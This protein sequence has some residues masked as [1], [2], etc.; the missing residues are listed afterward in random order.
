MRSRVSTALRLSTAVLILAG[1]LA[2]ATV[3]AYGP[4]ILAIPAAILPLAPLGEACDR[5]FSAYRVITRAAAIIY[6][7][8]IPLTVLILGLMNAVIALIVFIQIYTLLKVKEERNYH[9]LFLMSFFLL[10]AACVQQPDAEIALVMLLFLVSA[11]WAF[12]TLRLHVESARNTRRA[13]P[14]IVPLRGS[15]VRAPDETNDLFDWGLAFCITLVSLSGALLT[16]GTF[17]LTPR[18]EAGFL[19]RSEGYTQ[20]TGLSRDISLTGAAYLR[21]DRS[22]VMRIEFPEEPGGRFTGPMYW[23]STSLASYNASTWSHAGL[24]ESYD[25]HTRYLTEGQLGSEAS[26]RPRNRDQ[27]AVHQVIYMDEV[28]EEGVPCLDLVQKVQVTGKPGKGRLAWARGND[29]TIVLLQQEVRHLSYEVWSEMGITNPDVLR[30]DPADYLNYMQP[31]DF[32]L[33]THHDLRPETRALAERIT[34]GHDT[35]YDKAAAIAQWLS[36]PD[37]EYTL[38]LPPMPEQGAI[39][40]FLLRVRRGHCQFFAGGMALMLRSLGIP[41]RVVSGYRGGEWNPA[42]RSYTVRASMAH[43]W[44]EVLFPSYGW[45]VFDPAPRGD[46]SP[47]SGWA[48]LL[49]AVSRNLLKAKMLWYQEVVAYDRAQQFQRLRNLSLGLFR[50]RP[51][52]KL[53]AASAAKASTIE[54]VGRWVLIAFAASLVVFLVLLRRIKIPQRLVLTEDQARAVRLYRRLCR[55]LARYGINTANRPA[56]EID[57]AVSFSNRFDASTV[58]SLITVY[59][60]VRFGRRTLPKTV[61]RE[62]QKQIRGLRTRP[63]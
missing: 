39:D 58:H 32:S 33:L 29:F 45:V 42:D 25:P 61:F 18:I 54:R 7:C 22:A 60:K 14:D 49:G 57:E 36:G 52:D 4:M 56:E 63:T 51:Q 12:L 23:R 9:H 24:T 1:Y 16:A 20:R 28:P 59:N 17:L 10:L 3:H 11:V 53:E 30:R 43:V 40:A 5:R 6:G 31:R 55:Q 21:E 41:A 50:E 34:A 2:L 8:F 46:D 19:G 13:A 35:V 38:N 26:S 37:F 62:L 44:V 15:K 48:R 47:L 27:R